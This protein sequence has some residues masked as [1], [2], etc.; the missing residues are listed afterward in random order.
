MCACEIVATMEP[1]DDERTLKKQSG[2]AKT[3][4]GASFTLKV[5]R[6]PDTGRD[7]VVDGHAETP[8]LL[9][10][11][12]PLCEF[13][14]ADPSVSRRHAVVEVQSG[15]LRFTDLCSTNGSR[16]NG[17]TVFDAVLH[18][19]ET[20]DV[21]STLMQV[22]ANEEY[23][24][25]LPPELKFGNLIGG[26]A[27]L[28]RMYP[29]F[30]KL[31]ATDLPMVIE[32][33]TGTGKEVLAEAIH[34]AS[35]RGTGPFV[36]FDCTTVAPNFIEA[37][38]FGHDRGAFTGAVSSQ[39]GLF[40]EANGGTLFIDEIGDLDLALQ[41][42]LLRA[43]DRAQVRRLGSTKWIAVNVRIISATRRDLDA[44]VQAGRFRDDL[45]FRLG[46][47][48]VELPPLR[49]RTGDIRMLA[50]LFWCDMGGDPAA[51]RPDF[52]AQLE[53]YS[54][55][56]NVRELK[57]A[58]ARHLAL[59]DAVAPLQR[60]PT[61]APPATPGGDFFEQ[62]LRECH[63]YALGR[64]RVIDEFERRFVPWILEVHGGHVGKAA[65]AA[66]IGRRYFQVLRGR[67][68]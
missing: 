61:S 49:R 37:T 11:K 39:R 18:G 35:G 32:G 12:G 13:R 6:G 65:E 46:A 7:L 60:A 57:H 15:G 55:P 16:V 36:V 51:L 52:L 20:V 29:L 3:R 63:S 42:K 2:V 14:L 34:D 19:G 22:E 10:G 28:R 58:L 43:I 31:A 33:E 59:G 47:A 1:R 21:G 27:E 23:E 66:G 5:V 56:G 44:E 64:Q 67:H 41:A 38:L 50:T 68:R 25:P 53:S 26:S 62:V 8:R 24:V 45:L 48:R 40:E 54:W 4:R 17:V 30:R 9:I